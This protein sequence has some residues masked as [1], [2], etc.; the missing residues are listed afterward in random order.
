MAGYAFE[1]DAVVLDDKELGLFNEAFQFIEKVLEAK[2]AEHSNAKEFKK[3]LA[4]I[5][6]V[7]QLKLDTP[8]NIK[9]AIKGIEIYF[10]KAD[11][12]TLQQ[13]N[14]FDKLKNIFTK[15][16]D[17]LKKMRKYTSDGKKI[18][19]AFGKNQNDEH[20][21]LK[22]NLTVAFDLIQSLSETLKKDGFGFSIQ[23]PF[24]LINGNGNLVDSKIKGQKVSDILQSFENALRAIEGKYGTN[25]VD[26]LIKKIG[27]NENQDAS[28]DRNKEEGQ[29]PDFSSEEISR[30][31]ALKEN[32]SSIASVK[33]A[34]DKVLRTGKANFEEAKAILKSKFLPGTFVNAAQSEEELKKLGYSQK[35]WALLSMFK[36]G[37]E[38]ASVKPYFELLKSSS[39]IAGNILSGFAWIFSFLPLS[40]LDK[41]E[42][43]HIDC[44]PKLPAKPATAAAAETPAAGK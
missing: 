19:E 2:R 17:A 34:I 5:F 6:R 33:E 26:E 1:K 28:K 38:V 35:F 20:T 41:E 39:G 14:N 9:Q 16:N 7:E 10:T 43:I 36:A 15:A 29:A 18:I 42:N 27:K 32:P 44:L 31:K 8:D 23:D 21:T 24:G 11:V 3:S 13:E 30:L 22:Q 40:G 12:A 25:N 37:S 4:L